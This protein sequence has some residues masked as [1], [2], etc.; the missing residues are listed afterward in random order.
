MRERRCDRGLRGRHIWR[1]DGAG[2]HDARKCRCECWRE[3]MGGRRCPSL[4]RYGQRLGRRRGRRRSGKSATVE[5]PDAD[6]AVCA[7]RAWEAH[8]VE[9]L[10]VLRERVIAG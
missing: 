1:E 6:K 10:D 9:E 8:V 4:G 2:G 5:D 7:A 3:R